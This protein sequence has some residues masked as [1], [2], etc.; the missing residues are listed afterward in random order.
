VLQ[1]LKLLPQKEIRISL[2]LQH[3]GSVLRRRVAAAQPIQQTGPRS[4][5]LTQKQSVLQWET[6]WWAKTTLCLFPFKSYF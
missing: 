5:L 3:E 4:S 6:K 2:T 1:Y